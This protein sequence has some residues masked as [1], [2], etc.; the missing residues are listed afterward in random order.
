[1]KS[2]KK[3]DLSVIIVNYNTVDFLG[4]CLYSVAF[5][6][7]VTWEVI[8][9]DNCSKDGSPDFV[10][11]KFPWVRLIAND[12]NLG[13]SR[14]NNQALKDCSGTYVYFLNP[15]TEVR[16]G[17]FKNMVDFM[18]SHPNVGLAGT[19]L[20]NPDGSPQSSIEIR[21]PGQRHARDELKGLKGDIAW[22]M[23]AS[24]IARLEAIKNIDGFDE[25]FF[26]YG[27]DLDLC[28]RIRKAGW[29]IGYIPEATVVHWGGQSE[30]NNLSVKVWEKKIKAEF[31]FYRKHYSSKAV[32]AIMRSNLLQT[33][34]RI[35]TLNLT[36][37]FLE[38]KEKALAKLD[39]YK[40]IQKILK[41][42]KNR[43]VSSA[44]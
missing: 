31:V 8:V 37:P 24:M 4:R 42:Q 25:H 17:A 14:A 13:F 30:R 40:L 18:D 29:G 43:I 36:L 19:Q 22:V 12:Q 33:Y 28:L 44:K 27:E 20:V 21:Y 9:V 10:R 6:S 26:L 23:G 3:L 16:F 15:D 41:Q 35:F 5:Q 11:E 38:N 32:R 2:D 34:W 1:M 7:N 39:K